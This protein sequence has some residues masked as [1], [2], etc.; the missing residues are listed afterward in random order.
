MICVIYLQ[1][2]IWAFEVL[3]SLTY[4]IITLHLL[5]GRTFDKF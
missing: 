2:A 4:V 3:R 1:V 5:E